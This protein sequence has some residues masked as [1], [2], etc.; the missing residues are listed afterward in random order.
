MFLV[1]TDA[2]SKWVE[3]YEVTRA[4]SQS[5]IEVLREVCSRF[6]LPKTIVS[7]NGSQFTSAEFQKYCKLNGT[8]HVTSPV[9]H[10]FSNGAEEN[11]VKSFKLG[12]K[13]ALLDKGQESIKTV[14]TRYLFMYRNSPHCTTGL[15]PSSLMLGRKVRTRFDLLFGDRR[16]SAYA[17]CFNKKGWK[18]VEIVRRVASNVY[19]CK[20]K[21]ANEIWKRHAD[22]LIKI[23]SFLKKLYEKLPERDSD[24]AGNLDLTKDLDSNENVGTRKDSDVR[25]S[26]SD[27]IT[28]E[29][30]T[31][32][33]SNVDK[34]E[35]VD[36]QNDYSVARDRARKEI[37]LPV[38]IAGI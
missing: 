37:K 35:D 11:A 14:L 38:R 4:D 3:V 34:T 22:Q 24:R 13:K 32:V 33:D 31:L 1:I 36:S 27:E 29:N 2:F 6:G 8:C 7:D 5:T 19:L 15:S 10:P 23:G 12:L 20:V 21:D 25:D 16:E 30:V 26:M 28:T 9:N 18:E 17:R